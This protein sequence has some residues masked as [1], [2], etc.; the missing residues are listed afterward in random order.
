MKVNLKQNLDQVLES[1]VVVSW[2]ELMRGASSGLIHIEYDFAP[3]GTLDALW[4]WSSIT[5]GH[6]LLACSYWMSPCKFHNTGAHFDNGYESAGLAHILG[7]VM[8]N[9]NEFALPPNL[10]RRG[11][12]QVTVPTEDESAAA[13][14][15]VHEACDR[16]PSILAEPTQV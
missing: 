6:W 5:V 13:A 15:T 10:G 14:A 11:L 9:Q 7:V 1:A 3:S 8:Q 4:I 2:T 12:L 16:I